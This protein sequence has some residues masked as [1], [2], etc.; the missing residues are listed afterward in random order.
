MA[1]P[2]IYT[3][4]KFICDKFDIN[5]VSSLSLF[6]YDHYS[7][8]AA[9]DQNEKVLAVHLYT[10]SEVEELFGLLQKDDLYQIDI[11]T[12]VFVH[13]A[14]F[15]LVPG[16][17]FNPSFLNTYISFAVE[18]RDIVPNGTSLE[19]NGL[20]LVGAVSKDFHQKLSTGKKSIQF[21]HGAVSFL[22]YCLKEK[23]N[24]LNQEILI[25]YFDNYFYLAAFAKQDLMVFNR[26]EAAEKESILKYV[27]GVV[28]Q[29]NFNRKLCRVNFFGDAASI[30]V[31]KEWGEKYF[32]NF[33][34][35]V[36]HSNIQYHEGPSKIQESTAFESSWVFI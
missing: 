1:N 29:L 22:S 27:F 26:F 25:Y 35:S 24:L 4:E 7:F 8:L 9:K 14:I 30:D 6:L 34:I 23:L 28:Q 10:F 12:E 31:S 18:S 13:N 36:P 5:L 2:A 3:Q 16:M 19:S 17:L 33:K 15:S 32:K 21:H 11:P 20:H